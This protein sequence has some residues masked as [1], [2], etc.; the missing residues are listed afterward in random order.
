MFGVESHQ[1]GENTQLYFFL[2]KW[3]GVTAA[4]LNLCAV[5]NI[6]KRNMVIIKGTSQDSNFI[7]DMTLLAVCA[8]YSYGLFHCHI[9][10]SVCTA[11]NLNFSYL[12]FALVM[13]CLIRP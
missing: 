9:Y 5:V 13:F 4:V 6:Y 10:P 8:R 7:Q 11:L 2:S 3:A 12:S 1:D